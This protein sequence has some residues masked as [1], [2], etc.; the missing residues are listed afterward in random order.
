MSNNEKRLR[1][2]MITTGMRSGKNDMY[3]ALVNSLY[4]GEPLKKA[5]SEV[6]TNGFYA[7]FT[8]QSTP[9]WRPNTYYH[10]P[11]KVIYNNPATIVIWDDGSKTVIKCTNKDTYSKEAGLALCF[12]KRHMGNDNSF[13]KILDTFREEDEVFEDLT[14][15]ATT[16]EIRGIYGLNPIKESK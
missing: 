5:S 2:I 9:R 4:R 15:I 11:I 14:G 6:N 12:M 8:S 3:A 16:N 13:H 1:E 7:T 10:E